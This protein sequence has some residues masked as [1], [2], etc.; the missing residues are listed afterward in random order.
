MVARKRKTRS[1]KAKVDKPSL[2]D[3]IALLERAHQDKLYVNDLERRCLFLEKDYN[4][5][6]E[7]LVNLLRPEQIEAAKTC[8]ITPE[9]YALEWIELVKEDLRKFAPGHANYISG[10]INLKGY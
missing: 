7:R 5:L 3:E 4:D 8:G 9:V 1:F 2:R 10:L 6:K